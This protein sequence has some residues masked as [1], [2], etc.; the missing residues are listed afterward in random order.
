VEDVRRVTG[1]SVSD[2][3]ADEDDLM[4]VTGASE[5]V[6]D[7]VLALLVAEVPVVVASLVFVAVEDVLSSF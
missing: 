4:R 2:A 5:L 1:A 6:A 3:E 7:A